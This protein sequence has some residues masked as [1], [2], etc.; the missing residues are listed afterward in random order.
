GGGARD[1]GLCSLESRGVLGGRCP[2]PSRVG[3]A[4]DPRGDPNP[5]LSRGPRLPGGQDGA[6]G[7]PARSRSDPD[8]VSPGPPAAHLRSTCRG[9]PSSPTPDTSSVGVPCVTP[10]RRI[11]V[12]ATTMAS[13]VAPSA[14]PPK[15]SE[16]QCAPRYSLDAPTAKTRAAAPTHNRAF[17]WSER[18]V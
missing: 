10:P 6:H 1:R 4:A 15:T 9:L 11:S 17:T 5:R 7:R 3:Q 2:L 8:R 18:P 14:H 12:A 13:Q 16:S